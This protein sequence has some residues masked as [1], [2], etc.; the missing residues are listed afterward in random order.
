MN[1][2][3]FGAGGVG[4][5][6][7][8]KL[9]K[10]GNKVTFIARGKHLEAIKKNGLQ[11]KSING[12]FT[13]FPKATN[14][15][16]EIKTK[17]DLIILGIKSWQIED[18][19]R[20][21]KPII[22]KNTLVLPLQNGA[23]NVDKLL[24]V[25]NAENVLAGLCRIVSKIKSP[26]IINHF[27]YE[28][29]II[30][31]EISNEKTNRVKKIKQTFDEA[32]FK[33]EIATDIQLAIWKKFLFIA[34]FSGLAAL[35]RT[36]IGVLRTSTYLRN[37]MLKTAK[38]IVKIANVKNINLSKIDIDK[39]FKIYDKLDPKTTASMQRDVMG[40]K[41]SEL[42]NF[43]GYVVNQGKKLKIK[44]PINELIYQTLLPQENSARN[45]N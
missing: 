45:L 25:L 37:L 5:Y 44:T 28:P 19:A 11:I 1:I 21:I 10:S 8:A 39:T 32:Q 41:P 12:N 34:T 38:E 13:V 14:S 24:A 4:G 18:V 22:S 15:L 31:G 33:N 42:E 40:N 3:V 20:Q 29:E 30:F 43:N 2:V 7:G 17:P 36:P 35:T 16:K 26:G 27:E 23:D 9:T 6:F